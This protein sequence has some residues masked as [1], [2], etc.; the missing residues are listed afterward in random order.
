MSRLQPSDPSLT[1]E[2][3]VTVTTEVVPEVAAVPQL[4]EV[5]PTDVVD[6]VVEAE[7]LEEVDNGPQD[8][9]QCHQSRAVIAIINTVTKLFTVSN[10]CHV[11]GSKKW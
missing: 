1:T 8:I 10:L 11:L 2:A 9:L 5:T 7:V 3:G 6:E 4:A